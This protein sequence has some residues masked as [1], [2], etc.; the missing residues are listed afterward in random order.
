M[1]WATLRQRNFSLLWFA[2][3]ISYIGNWMLYIALPVSVYELTES[4]LAVSAMLIATILPSIALG[5]V[6]GVF[7]DRWERKRTMVIV[8]LLLA[9]SIL[10]LLL[11]N[12]ADWLWLVFIIRFVQSAL[13]QF[14]AP[15][16]GAM[17][18]QLVAPEYL[19]SA[20]ALNSLNNSLARLIG[21]AVGG[22]IVAVVG[23]GGVVMIDVLTY[24]IAAA[25]LALITVT[26]KP[27]NPAE[28]SVQSAF[29]KTKIEWLD[30]LRYIKNR[31]IVRILFICIAITSIGEGVMS[32]LFVPFVHNVLRGEAVHVGWLVSAQAVGSLL[33]GVVIGWIGVRSQPQRLLAVGALL[34]GII[35]LMIFNYSRFLPG[36]LPALVLFI[37]VGIPVVALVTGFDT[38][39]QTS[40]ED[41]FRGRV[42]GAFGTTTSLFAL[43]GT[44]FAGATGDIIGIVPVINIQAFGYL[45]VG[46]I[47][48]FVFRGLRI[49][50]RQLAETK[51]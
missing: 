51:T 16:E 3:L 27:E 11:V 13:A 43:F 47:C 7:V 38:L 14:F 32:T 22:M 50:A 44:V 18:P 6:A 24:L 15:A 34:L 2:G 35:D 49:P 4:T 36:V 46:I 48:L 12:S 42:L 37:I 25:L 28:V 29:A 26:S 1:M 33:G 8:N 17:L 31:P 30:G 19:V 5:S 41:R 23:L 10:P 9:L 39:L 21:P 45:I 20:N 40:V